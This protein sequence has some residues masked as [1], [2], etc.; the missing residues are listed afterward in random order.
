MTTLKANAITGTSSLTTFLESPTLPTPSYSS[1]NTLLATTAVVKSGLTTSTHLTTNTAQALSGNN[2]FSNSTMSSLDSSGAIQLGEG[3]DTVNIGTTNL[4][5][6]G[7][8]HF[9]EGFLNFAVGSNSVAGGQAGAKVTQKMI[10][11]R[12]DINGVVVSGSPLV[13][14]LP[15]LFPT[16]TGG[17][18]PFINTPTVCLTPTS[19]SSTVLT[20]SNYWVTGISNAGFTINVATSTTSKYI[21]WVAVGH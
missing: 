9:L 6:N 20:P 5:I 10:A 18:V 12:V 3:T 2:Y 16:L 14:S 11:G 4:I 13:G 17:I 15:V 7:I 19:F 8:Q 1:N 21:N